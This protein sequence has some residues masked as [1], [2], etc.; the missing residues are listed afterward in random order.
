MTSIQVAIPSQADSREAILAEWEEPIS[1]ARRIKRA[2]GVL[3]FIESPR[4]E[5][6]AAQRIEDMKRIFFMS[7]FS[8]LFSFSSSTIC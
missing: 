3:L 7:R 5:K 6:A 8:F 2:G 4:R 1:S